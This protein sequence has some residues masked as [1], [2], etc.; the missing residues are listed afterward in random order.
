MIT[1]SQVR[2]TITQGENIADTGG[3]SL[4]FDAYR[5]WL[6]RHLDAGGAEEMLLPGLPL[7]VDQAFFVSYGQVLR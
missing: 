5:K 3:L 7:S 6:R 4:S 2:G 1:P